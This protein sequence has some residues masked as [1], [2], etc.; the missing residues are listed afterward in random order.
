MKPYSRIMLALILVMI[1]GIACHAKLELGGNIFAEFISD[2]KNF[3]PSNPRTDPWRS[4]DQGGIVLPG[5]YVGQFTKINLNMKLTDNQVEAFVPLTLSVNPFSVRGES[6]SSISW[7]A[8]LVA[9]DY[10]NIPYHFS[11]KVPNFNFAASSKPIGDPR[12][13]FV[14]FEDSLGI[15]RRPN[16]LQPLLTFKID[17]QMPRE[18]VGRAYVLFDQAVAGIPIWERIPQSVV[19]EPLGGSTIGEFGF[20]DEVA[21]YKF[22]QVGKNT[23]F[24]Q[25]GFF[26]GQK[27]VENPSFR[28]KNADSS[29]SAG[30]VFTRWGYE[31]NNYGFDFKT[32]VGSN[33]QINTTVFGSDV[34]WYQYDSQR[35]VDDRGYFVKRWY[36]S[37]LKGKLAGM[38]GNFK[39]DLKLGGNRFSLEAIAVEP[40]FQAVAAVQDQFS[41]LERLLPRSAADQV[42][43]RKT[44]L[45]FDPAGSLLGKVVDSSPVVDYLGKRKLALIFAKEG[46]I[47]QLPV[48]FTIRGQDIASLDG[49]GKLERDP[50]TGAYLIKD[51]RGVNVSLGYRGSQ[52]SWLL[53]GENSNFLADEDYIKALRA[54]AG[55]GWQSVNLKNTLER[56]WRLKGSGLENNEGTTTKLTSTLSG[57]L[58]QTNYSL[59]LDLRTGNYDYDLLE[60]LSDQVVSPYSYLGL[61]AYLEKSYEFKVKN[62]D[63]RLTIA[64]EMIKKET[65]LANVKKG[66]SLVGYLDA[67]YPLGFRWDWITTNIFVQGPVQDN[68]PSGR[69][70]NISHNELVYTHS[71]DAAV[72]IGYTVFDQEH[73]NGFV[74][75]K[76]ALGQGNLGV[77]FGRGAAPIFKE[78]IN[79]PGTLARQDFY[80][81][82]YLPT[83][84][85][86]NRPWQSWDENNFAALWQNQLRSTEDA[87]AGYMMVSYWYSF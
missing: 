58:G 10:L 40:D 85:L 51:Q 50:K 11:M 77:S 27:N 81:Q 33:L 63:A 18:Y 55:H 56:V 61:S 4:G 86:A 1:V 53:E 73:H 28:M 82:D 49:A 38:A 48:T 44:Q 68:L 5:Y 74:S 72:R 54:S 64:G 16:S 80:H 43:E 37:E 71:K 36:P 24:G 84:V 47:Y 78:G 75:L 62:R 69:L 29:L 22:A 20:I 39:A 19:A 52:N 13:G 17:A 70:K 83:Q 32:R 79:L 59:A 12:F 46:Q 14:E 7:Q 31:K 35:Q 87:W 67:R 42:L 15:M 30:T 2:P 6:G 45:I 8:V 65:D 60:P 23:K 66:N 3:D 21:Q 26:V 57:N 25:L 9:E 34:N 41:P 76:L